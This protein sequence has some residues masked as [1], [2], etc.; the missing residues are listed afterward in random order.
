MRGPHFRRGFTLIELLVVIAIIAILI[1]LLVPAVQKV[2]AA[3]AN[4][5]CTNNLKQLA[6]ACHN[7]HDAN[8][9]FPPAVLI[10]NGVNATT[11]TQNFG[12]NW[13]VL[14]LPYIEQGTMWTPAVQT[15]VNTYM[16]TG[17]SLWNQ[18]ASNVLTVM[19]CPFDASNH[20]FAYTGTATTNNA[21]NG[22]QAN[23]AHGNYACNAGGIHQPDTTGT[24]DVSATGWL[25]T[26]NGA[27][28]QYGTDDPG[29]FNNGPVPASR[30]WA[31][32]CASTGGSR[33]PISPTAVRTRFCSPRCAPVNSSAAAT[34]ADS[35]PWGCPAQRDL[36]PMPAGTVRTPTTPTTAPTTP[37]EALMPRLNT[38]DRG[39]AVPSS[40]PRPAACIRI[41]P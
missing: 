34:R 12:P 24:S 15:S 4:I 32:S 29:Q 16:A 38:W 7:Y 31:A 18:V 41:G 14:I 1:A 9:K 28:P 40:K 17:D 26:A 33:C 30:L 10:Q 5:Q 2:R 3:A 11:A 35:G 20:G 21:P 8:K 25:S 37:R 13:V 19:I 6:L 23:W 27:S 22:A 36:R 39:A